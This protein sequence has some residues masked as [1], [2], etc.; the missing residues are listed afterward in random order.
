MKTTLVSLV[1]CLALAAC[2][3]SSSSSA[4]SCAWQGNYTVTAGEPRSSDGPAGLCPTLPAFHWT[5]AE[6]NG[7]P[8]LPEPQGS[9]P[10]DTSNNVD[11][12]ACT[13]HAG[14]RSTATPDNGCTDAGEV[15]YDLVA[16]TSSGFTGTYTVVQ[17]QAGSGSALTLTC[18]YDVTGARQ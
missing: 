1:A 13:A 18:T 12:N 9:E 7:H 2:S 4:P 6:T 16:F 5:L 10:I 11:A 3:S 14:Y 15:H 17:C 8:V